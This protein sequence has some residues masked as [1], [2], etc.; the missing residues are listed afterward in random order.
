MRPTHLSFK[1]ALGDEHAVILFFLHPLIW[2]KS[3]Q[4]F[5][6]SEK[7]CSAVTS[8]QICTSATQRLWDLRSNYR[9]ASP[10]HGFASFLQDFDCLTSQEGDIHTKNE[11][12]KC[13]FRCFWPLPS[14][15]KDAPKRLH[16]PDCAV[17][18]TAPHPS[19]NSM[20]VPV[21]TITSDICSYARLA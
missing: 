13:T 6:A 14:L 11:H 3:I 12:K 19:P 21:T 8:V 16:W 1:Q 7:Y 4:F 18:T 9:I 5:C 15:C 17:I 2:I 10:W 20:Q